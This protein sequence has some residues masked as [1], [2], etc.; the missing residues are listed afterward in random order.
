MCFVTLTRST[1]C[2]SQHTHDTVLLQVQALPQ[3]KGEPIVV[4]RQDNI[5]FCRTA[6]R[7]KRQTCKSNNSFVSKVETFCKQAAH[8]VQSWWVGISVFISGWDVSQMVLSFMSHPKDWTLSPL[9][10]RVGREGTG[11]MSELGWETSVTE[12]S[13]SAQEWRI[14]LYKSNQSINHLVNLW[15]LTILTDNSYKMP[16]SNMS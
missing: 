6:H 5:S 12:H 3:L 8:L 13:E 14:A 7:M 2:K 1:W 16:F 4:S 9:L 11:F 15:I 10:V